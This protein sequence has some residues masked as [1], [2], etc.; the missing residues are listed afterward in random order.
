MIYVA[1]LVEEHQSHNDLAV[2][3][4]CVILFNRLSLFVANIGIYF[5]YS[6]LTKIGYYNLRENSQK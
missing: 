1:K 4:F 5:N 3:S 2:L 6:R